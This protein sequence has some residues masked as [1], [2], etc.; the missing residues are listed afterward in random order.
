MSWLV[1]LGVLNMSIAN[2]CNKDEYCIDYMQDCVL[3]GEEFDWCTATLKEE[4]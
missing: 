2:Y 3:D 1:F 4:E